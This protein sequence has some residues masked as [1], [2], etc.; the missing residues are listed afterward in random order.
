M[1]ND[2]E[3]LEKVIEV[4]E[5]LFHVSVNHIFSTMST[6]VDQLKFIMDQQ[7]P[8]YKIYPISICDLCLRLKTLIKND[9]KKL[10]SSLISFYSYRKSNVEEIRNQTDLFQSDENYLMNPKRS[11]LYHLNIL[12]QS[13]RFDDEQQSYVGLMIFSYNGQE[14]FQLNKHFSR[15]GDLLIKKINTF[16]L[17]LRQNQYPISRRGIYQTLFKWFFAEN[18]D[19]RFFGVG[20]IYDNEQWRFDTITSDYRQLLPFEYRI[21]DLFLLT[22]WL[23]DQP[24]AH[25]V[26]KMEDEAKEILQNQFRSFQQRLTNPS[27]IK[28]FIEI[29]QKMFS[30]DKNEFFQAIEYFQETIEAEIQLLFQLFTKVSIP[31][32]EI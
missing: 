6:K 31:I 11:R 18:L 8:E 24:V 7:R 13:D 5:K 20:F 1:S 23:N 3:K 32:A 12:P 28:E 4:N 22:H 29:A 10:V 30:L 14:R 16:P 2:Q 19:E 15:Q 21:L 17:H 26:Q 27:Q 25:Y 9:S